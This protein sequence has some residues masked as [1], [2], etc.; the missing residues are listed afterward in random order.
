MKKEMGGGVDC[1]Y[2]VMGYGKM[3]GREGGREGR[4]LFLLI[5][6]E[7]TG[8]VGNRRVGSKRT[9]NKRIEN[10]QDGSS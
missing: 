6:G 8:R 4:F 9:D 7:G 5:E 10:D 1:G 2:E 3:E